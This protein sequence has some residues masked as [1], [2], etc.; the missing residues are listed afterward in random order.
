[1]ETILSESEL[2]RGSRI[3]DE[4]LSEPV[5]CSWK[6]RLRIF[7]RSLR[8]LVNLTMILPGCRSV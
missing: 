4:M 5:N 2:A 3:E 7:S 1:M 6:K 8:G